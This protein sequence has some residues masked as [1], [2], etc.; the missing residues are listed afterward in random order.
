[1][2]ALRGDGHGTATDTG[3]DTANQV[4]LDMPTGRWTLT[5]LMTRP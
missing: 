3:M 2:Q 1:M 5:A 4:A